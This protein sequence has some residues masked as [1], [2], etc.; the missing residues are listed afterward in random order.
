MAKTPKEIKV[1]VSKEDAAN[2]AV[3]SLCGL[4]LRRL[5]DQVGVPGVTTA[6]ETPVTVSDLS[7]I[8]GEALQ[9]F[10]KGGEAK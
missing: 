5:Q 3:A 6:D 8:F 10:S 9:Q 4:V 2:A 7:E 1:K